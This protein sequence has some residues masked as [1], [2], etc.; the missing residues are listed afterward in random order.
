M[1]SSPSNSES[2]TKKH[3]NKKSKKLKKEKKSKSKSKSII[4][5]GFLPPI[6]VGSLASLKDR[7]ESLSSDDGEYNDFKEKRNSYD[8]DLSDVYIKKKKK[9]KS[10][11]KHK[12][13]SSRV[14]VPVE[15][16]LKYSGFSETRYYERRRSNTSPVEFGGYPEKLRN[17]A[18]YNRRSPRHR[19]SQSRYSR[20]SHDKSFSPY[21]RRTASPYNSDSISYRSVS[22]RSPRYSPYGTYGYKSPY[23][24]RSPQ[25][26]RKR[27][28]SPTSSRSSQKLS[29]S[30]F[31]KAKPDLQS[32]PKLPMQ[33]KRIRTDNAKSS[34]IV[35]NSYLPTNNSI[36]LPQTNIVPPTT[37]MSMSQFFMSQT[38]INK[39]DSPP[40]AP[41]AVPLNVLGCPPPPPLQSPP[42]VPPPPSSAPPPPLPEDGKNLNVPPLPP[43]PLPPNIP[44]IDMIVS[45]PELQDEVENSQ[46]VTDSQSSLSIDTTSNYSTPNSMH[47]FGKDSEWGERCVDMF[48]IITIVGE[49]TY[50]QVFKAKDKLTGEM[51]ALKKVRLDKE[52]EGF[53]ITAVRE[54]KILRQLSHPSIV[55]LKEIVTDK[56]SAL[57]FRKDKGDFY[58]VFEYC[59]HDLMGILE[60]GFV[61]F[62]TEHISS[63]MKQLMEGL[64]Y[65]HGKHFLH[66]DIKCS[67]ILMSNRGEIKLADFGLARLFESENEGRQ[68]TNRVITLWY[69][70]PELLLG[71]ERYGPAIDVW[72]CGCILGELFR[73]K[74]LFLG[75]TEIVQLDLISRVCGTPTPAVWPDVIHLPLYNTFKLKKQYKRKIKEEYASLPKDALD[76]LDQMLVLDPS[77]RITS[78]ETLKHPFLKNTVPEKVVPPK[79]PAW[80]DCHEMWS[81][82]RKRQARL[83][84]QTKGVACKPEESMDFF[85][86]N[87]MKNDGLPINSAVGDQL[88]PPPP[89]PSLSS[90]CRKNNSPAESPS[91]TANSSVSPNKPNDTDKLQNPPVKNDINNIN[92][93]PIGGFMPSVNYYSSL[94]TTQNNTIET[95]E[96]NLKKTRRTSVR[97]DIQLNHYTSK[98]VN[99]RKS[100][101]SEVVSTANYAL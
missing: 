13:I 22:P 92:Y 74:P 17:D 68:Y 78:E 85:M 42:S 93:Q 71:E 11:R 34:N 3:K 30:N 25:N 7:Y 58:L 32:S 56:Q 46:N 45:S 24:R 49:G 50:G 48:E 96:I 14:E 4:T 87:E 33:R 72:S 23:N 1:V 20:K 101:G 39:R 64:N 75:N 76:L 2:L 69:R 77:K 100:A 44:D 65:C 21:D 41:P 10:D 79:F 59:D 18:A 5:S 38:Q 51:V 19:T 66:R 35:S 82:E 60:S 70:P 54:I 98:P 86:N 80:Q 62:T 97:S 67:N 81:K 88:P 83:D 73:R 27:S 15:M 6:N 40:P 63:M 16:P 53:P 52:K 90:G 89:L 95:S 57:D 94:N 36:Y 61:Q 37:Q 8:K 43:L 9:H 91:V 26:Y 47:L 99:F 12:K 55:N 29:S 84:A 28:I 31:K